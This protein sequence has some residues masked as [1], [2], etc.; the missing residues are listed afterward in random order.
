[1][2]KRF[3]ELFSS[4]SL[5]DEAY[6]TTVTMLEFDHKM[7]DASRESL[8]RSD[9]GELPFDIRKTDRKINKYE[10]DVRRKVVTHLTV[11][12]T[13]NLVPGLML[14]SIVI[15]VERIGDYTK[16]IAGLATQHKRRL[17]GG[18]S[19]ESLVSI[20]EAIEQ[21]FPKVIDVLKT[22]DKARAREVM[23]MEGMVSKA[24]DRIVDDM[25]LQKDKTLGVGNSVCLAMYA[26]FLK[27]INAHLANIA[28]SIVNPFP[29]IGFR[30]KKGND[31]R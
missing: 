16:N 2:F 12:G 1:M 20:E 14:V 28:S 30:E 27:R 17:K 10:R 7:Y 9:T 25:I 8:R 26:R 18:K 13:Q 22:Q 23:Q 19:E 3:K 29:R 24:S 31:N 5:L 21:N 11:A 4:E 15:D 6:S